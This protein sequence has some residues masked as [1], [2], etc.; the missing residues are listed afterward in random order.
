MYNVNEEVLVYWVDDQ[1]IG[2]WYDG[3]IRA[4]F[5]KSCRIIFPNYPGWDLNV[6]NKHIR[7][8]KRGKSL[9]L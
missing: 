3:V 9:E 5:K 7:R 6:K 8:K 4:V 2:Y 1:K